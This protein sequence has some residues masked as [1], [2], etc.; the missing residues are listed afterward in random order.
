M[1]THATK[2]LPISVPFLAISTGVVVVSAA[3][4]IVP[5]TWTGFLIAILGSWCFLFAIGMLIRHYIRAAAQP[6]DPT[7]AASPRC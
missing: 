2:R 7:D 4:A 1:P 5:H 6:T 3:W